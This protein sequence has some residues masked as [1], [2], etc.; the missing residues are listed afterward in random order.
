MPGKKLEKPLFPGKKG[1]KPAHQHGVVSVVAEMAGR[2]GLSRWCHKPFSGESVWRA[3]DE[4]PSS[5]ALYAPKLAR[6]SPVQSE[7]RK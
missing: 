1:A 7:R 3:A 2:G 5:T 6:K 4:A